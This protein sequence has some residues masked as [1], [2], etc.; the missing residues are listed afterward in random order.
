MAVHIVYN[1][2]KTQNRPYSSNDI[3]TNLHNEYSKAIVQNAIDQLVAD[4]KLFEKVYGK[5]KIYCIIQDSKHDIDELIRIE[6]ELQTHANEIKSKY[7]EV[8][9]EI[10]DNEVLLSSLKSSP[11]QKDLETEKITLQQNIRQIVH[12]LDSLMETTDSQDLHESKRKV[13]TQMDEN[14][15]Q[16]LKRKRLC[17]EI[18]DCILEN[19]PGGKDELYEEIEVK[20]H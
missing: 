3:V 2:M 19:Y 11:T 7:K 14:S 1:Y 18:I 5:Q 8:M 20:A 15:R 10:K 13:K 12:K 16:Y 4:G 17:T 6:K 9:K